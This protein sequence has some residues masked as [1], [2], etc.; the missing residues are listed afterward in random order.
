MGLGGGLVRRVFSKSRASADGRSDSNER[1]CVEH[2]NRWS[3]VRHY[4][5]GDEFNSDHEED[6]I[7]SSKSSE[8]TVLQ[9]AAEASADDGEESIHQAIKSEEHEE[10]S[11]EEENSSLSATTSTRTT[12][13]SSREEED[14]AILIQSA[15]KGFMARRQLK[16]MKKL[17]ERD[18]SGGTGNPDSAS[19]ASSTEVQVGGSVDT[20]GFSEESVEMQQKVQQRAR[21]QVFRVKEEWDDSTVSCNELKLRIQNRLE[22]TNRRERALAYAF[23]Q[24]L[25]TCNTK[26]RSTRSDQTEPNIGWSWLER[27]MATRPPESSSAE[28]C[29]SKH[30]DTISIEKRS[31]LI[32]KRFDVAIEE[33]ESCGSNDVCVSF[34]GSSISTPYQ[35][36][37]GGYRHVKNRLKATRSVSRR[38]TAFDYRSATRSRKVSNKEHQRGVDKGKGNSNNKQEQAKNQAQDEDYD[39]YCELPPGY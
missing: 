17:G 6:E 35:T 4:L 25:R 18:E 3:S 39:A 12:T 30:F 5:C 2:K 31:I 10:T 9:P 34:D 11:T 8:A 26:K 29:L 20:L 38:K 19:V 27:W 33:R 1:S 24:Q 23:S 16:E 32:K 21:P 28:D 15:F 36:P 13:K 7:A 22:A 14:A 37:R